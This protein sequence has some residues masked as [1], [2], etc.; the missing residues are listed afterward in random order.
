MKK[1]EFDGIE[2]V[3]TNETSPG[4]RQ[5]SAAQ[6]STRRA[7]RHRAARPRASGR[8]LQG[9]GMDLLDVSIRR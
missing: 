9:T 7:R 5:S 4:I 8:A 1:L 2:S 3:C 6:T